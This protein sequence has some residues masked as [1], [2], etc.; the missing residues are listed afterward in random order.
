MKRG[1]YDFLI[2]ATCT[3]ALFATIFLIKGIEGITYLFSIGVQFSVAA[4]LWHKES[5]KAKAIGVILLPLLLFCH[6]LPKNLKSSNKFIG[7][8]D[9]PH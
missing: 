9:S 8:N 2:G 6:F 1:K 7:I 5:R 4:M 3:L